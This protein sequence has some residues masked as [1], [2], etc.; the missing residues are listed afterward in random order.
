L[1][2]AV[3]RPRNRPKR[4]GEAKTAI[5]PHMGL[6]GENKGELHSRY[7]LRDSKGQREK[8]PKEQ[9]MYRGVERGVNP[10]LKE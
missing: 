8:V 7:K 1:L 10:V 4:N 5:R 3:L 2:R 6:E 9:L